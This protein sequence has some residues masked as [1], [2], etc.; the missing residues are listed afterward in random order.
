MNSNAK[1]TGFSPEELAAEP[2]TPKEEPLLIAESDNVPCNEK[3][4]LPG[5]ESPDNGQDVGGW[6]SYNVKFTSSKPPKKHKKKSSPASTMEA[7]AQTQQI[8]YDKQAL[9]NLTSQLPWTQQ[10]TNFG[11]P[12]INVNGEPQYPPSAPPTPKIGEY[13]DFL[14]VEDIKKA[15]ASLKAAQQA[16]QAQVNAKLDAAT[17][18]SYPSSATMAS[19]SPVFTTTP[20]T[21]SSFS[22]PTYQTYVMGKDAVFNTN[23]GGGLSNPQL[24]AWMKET[25][26]LKQQLAEAKE[27]IKQLSGEPGEF[28][29][30]HPFDLYELLN[31]FVIPV[32]LNVDQDMKDPGYIEIN[33]KKYKQST[34]MPITSKNSSVDASK[35]TGYSPE[36]GQK[37]FDKFFKNQIKPKEYPW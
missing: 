24:D 7:L 1:F 27:I 4:V 34:M 16:E 12:D 30:I 2:E 21:V 13:D 22:E 20:N 25:H 31:S 15:A 9:A 5:F 18:Y 37:A 23:W 29:Y 26:W 17:Y 35:Y 10:Y 8:Y 14:T 28:I 36:A 33:G 11:S 32:S 19:G 6:T 3:E